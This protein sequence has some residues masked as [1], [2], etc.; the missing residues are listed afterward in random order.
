MQYPARFFSLIDLNSL[1]GIRMFDNGG[2][3]GQA[4][5]YNR[6]LTI[7]TA[8]GYVESTCLTRRKLGNDR[9]KQRA[10]ASKGVF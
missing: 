4:F 8:T 3:F 5:R 2:L 6:S 9:R 7:F 10:F 1:S